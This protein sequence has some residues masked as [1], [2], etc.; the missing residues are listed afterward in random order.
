MTAPATDAPP[1]A[2]GVYAARRAKTRAFRPQRIWPSLV[3]G[4][5]LAAVMIAIAVAVVSTLAGRPVLALRPAPLVGR[6]TEVAWNDPAATGAAAAVV[7][8]GV[9]CLLL[10]CLPGRLRD[11]PMACDDPDVALALTRSGLRYALAA[12]ATDVDGADSAKV[13]VR[14]RRVR[15]TVA[16]PLRAPGALAAQVREAVGDRLRELEPA[17]APRVSVR[18]RRKNT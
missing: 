9:V 17:R 5:V 4:A 10:A 8:A 12:A 2:T 3:V 1:A 11:I 13:R 7:A 18:V 6:L 16:T 14:V 15:V